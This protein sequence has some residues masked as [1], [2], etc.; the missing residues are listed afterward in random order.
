ML[1]SGDSNGLLN[2]PGLPPCMGFSRQRVLDI[3]AIAFCLESMELIPETSKVATHDMGVYKWIQEST[4][5]V[6]NLSSKIK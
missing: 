4:E 3:I 1:N 2:L 6:S 5:E